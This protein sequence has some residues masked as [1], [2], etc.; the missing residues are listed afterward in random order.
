MWCAS[1]NKVFDNGETECPA[2]GG[3]L[4][5]FPTITWEN[6]KKNN[7]LER[8]P[9]RA[10]GEPEQPIFLTKCSNLNLED[11]ML[12]SMLEAY[13]IP[14]MRQYPNDGKFG[15]LYLGVSGGGVE[16]FVPESMLEDARNIIESTGEE[17]DLEYE[18]L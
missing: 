2:C 12:V 5:A 11:S 9:V 17:V 3:E 4:G 13:D 6:A 15:R 8:W 7:P 14:T 16:I 10:D 1:C 18:E